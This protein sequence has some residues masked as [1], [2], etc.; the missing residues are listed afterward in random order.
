MIS[1]FPTDQPN[2]NENISATTGTIL[3][4]FTSLCADFNSADVDVSYDAVGL[5]IAKTLV[6]L[7]THLRDFTINL[8]FRPAVTA[9]TVLLYYN[10]D[11]N[12]KKIFLILIVYVAGPYLSYGI[13]ATV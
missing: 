8:I 3:K 6:D 12:K 1:A 13:V 4:M 9:I 5:K 10:I 2:V 7:L 11:D